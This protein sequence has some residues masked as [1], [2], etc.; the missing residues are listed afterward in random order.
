MTDTVAKIC[1]NLLFC[2]AQ[3]CSTVR[4]VWLRDLSQIIVLHSCSNRWNC[5]A[6]CGSDDSKSMYKQSN[7]PPFEINI[8]GRNYICHLHCGNF[9]TLVIIMHD[10][11]RCLVVQLRASNTTEWIITIQLYTDIHINKPMGQHPFLFS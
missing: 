5:A 8:E 1:Y 7:S 9:L 2:I 11:F 10:R 6:E 4:R 3:S